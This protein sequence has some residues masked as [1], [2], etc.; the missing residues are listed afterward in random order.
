[1][2]KDSRKGKASAQDRS[3]PGRAPSRPIKSSS[4]LE[5]QPSKGPSGASSSSASARHTPP[6][7]ASYST[8]E[9]PI[10]GVPLPAQKKARIGSTSTDIHSAPSTP[11]RIK[12]EESTLKSALRKVPA[13]QQTPQQPQQA[14]P[15]HLWSLTLNVRVE[16]ESGLINL[17]QVDEEV[18]NTF[19]QTSWS[20]PPPLQHIRTALQYLKYNSLK[21]DPVIT[22]GLLRLAQAMPEL[23]RDQVISTI[24]IQMLRPEFTH[25]FKIRT[26]GAVVFLVCALL[27]LAWDDV[28]DWPTDFVMAYLEDASGERSW[29]A[30]AD[31]EAFVSNILTAFRVDDPV[32]ETTDDSFDPV[33]LDE[34]TS[35]SAVMVTIDFHQYTGSLKLRRRYRDTTTR[36]NIKHVTLQTMWEHIPTAVGAS[37]VETSVRSLIKVMM[38]TCRWVEVRLKAMSC[39]EFWLG[40]FL[41]NAKPLLRLALRQLSSQ[42]T[43]SREDLESWTMLLDFRYK[44]RG[45]HVETVKDELRVALHGLSGRELIQTGLNHIMEVELN[46]NELKNPHHLDLMELFLQAIPD[47]PAVEF[48]QLIQGCVVDAALLMEGSTVSPP[49]ASVVLVVKRWIRHLGKRSMTWTTDVVIGLLMEG[50]SLSR[51]GQKHEE[52]RHLYAPSGGRNIPTMWLLMLTEIICNVMMATVIDAKEA[53]DIK[54]GKFTIEQVHTYSLRWF[55]GISSAGLGPTALNEGD[56]CKTPFGPVPLD[57]LRICVARLLFL[58]PPQTYAMDTTSQEF[59]TTL[60]Y[61]VI[62]NGLPLTEGG[63]LALLDIRLPHKMLL[64]IVG[65]YVSRA[66]DLSRLYPESC[67][68]KNPQVIVKVF[69]LSRFCESANSQVLKLAS[70]IPLA[71]TQSFWTCS[72]IVAMLA[73]CNLRILALVVWDSMPV[74]RTLLELC[75]SQHYT[76]PPPNYTSRSEPSS[77]R[78]LRLSIEADQKDR[79]CVL[80]WETDTLIAVGQWSESRG[81]NPLQPNESEYVGWLMRLDFGVTQPARAPPAEIMQQ[82]RGMN[83]RF[84]MGMK[85]AGSRD[86][87]YLGRMVGNNDD[88]VWVDRLLRD[89]PE[90]L[91]ALPASTLCARYCRSI[92]MARKDDLEGS[93][94][95]IDSGLM[96]SVKRKLTGYLEGVMDSNTSPLNSSF[97]DNSASNAQDAATRFQEVREIFEY[98]LVRLSLGGSSPSSSFTVDAEDAALEIKQAMGDLFQGALSWPNVLLQTVR[99]TPETG[100]FEKSLHWIESFVMSEIEVEW[101]AR[102][103]EFLLKVDGAGDGEADVSLEQSLLTT[104]TLLT[105]RLFVFDWLVRE[106][107]SLLKDLRKRVEMYFLKQDSVME[108]V[109]MKAIDQSQL[110]SPARTKVAVELSCGTTMSTYPEV[111]RLALLVL[112]TTETNKQVDS[113]W[114]RLF[115]ESSQTVP[116]VP[117]RLANGTSLLSRELA[118][119]NDMQY[120]LRLVQLCKDPEI[121]R[122]AMDGLS[123]VEVIEMSK[124]AFGIDVKNAEVMHEALLAALEREKEHHVPVHLDKDASQRLLSLLSYYADRGSESSRQ[125][126]EVVRTRFALDA[127]PQTTSVVRSSLPMALPNFFQTAVSR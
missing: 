21:P 55:Q 104:A 54:V 113:T 46:P 108:D 80:A 114:S 102:S 51:L 47:R 127:R 28:E 24:M 117:K 124:E 19:S 101:I 85:L 22:S 88:A 64:A 95:A 20:T 18:H 70:D 105:N 62:D 11:P 17:R 26:N 4:K 91:N 103:L 31:T 5:P 43:L 87:D 77:E 71:W 120:R 92:A 52:S 9:S 7:E 67:I 98:F 57:A 37:A 65:E 15:R 41:K 116:H 96:D 49:L 10:D 72:L 122:V 48:G 12:S 34:K 93:M 125:A 94:A 76:F 42:P 86:P 38:V 63:L 45:H 123:L 1:M 33:R 2:S 23:L 97:F 99:K 27:H 25:S 111:L 121:V 3:L 75:I 89:V 13:Q 58:D 8:P 79:E 81:S 68:V 35:S 60:I 73:T 109:S 14:R 84:G 44:G 59:D 29:C 74:V 36:S 126:L 61:K 119:Q 66:T 83:E 90:I 56:I 69:D 118:V 100:F 53:K 30:H 40:S 6:L 82:L 106:R 115:K 78:L 107:D 50:P 112:S 32:D 16:Q 39:M 110:R